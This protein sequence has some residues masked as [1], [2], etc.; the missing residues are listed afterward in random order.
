MTAP[1]QNRQEVLER[2]AAARERLAALGVLS[3]GLF[4]SFAT[5]RQTPESDVDILVEFAPEHHSFD[6]F[7]EVSF[8]L[9]DILARK[10]ELVTPQALSPHI[11]P[12]ILREV[13]RVRIAS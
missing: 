7:M 12:H 2:L 13:Q 5:G 10:V 6:N 4:G 9:E 1:A 11:G 3:I 8:L